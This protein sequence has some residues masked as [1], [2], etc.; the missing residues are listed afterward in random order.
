M[1]TIK[2]YKS[3][4]IKEMFHSSEWESSI[5]EVEDHFLSLKD[6]DCHVQVS[7]VWITNDLISFSIKKKP[8]YYPGFIVIVT[9][10]FNTSNFDQHIEYLKEISDCNSRIPDYYGPYKL[11]QSGG[12]SGDIEKCVPFTYKFIFLDKNWK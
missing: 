7:G 11:E 1:K 8:G 5:S 2:S 4:Y 12:S 9:P 6:N 10:K 3:F